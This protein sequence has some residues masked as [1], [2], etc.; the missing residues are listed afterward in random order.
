MT[1]L[2]KILGIYA[3][4]PKNGRKI[5]IHTFSEDVQDNRLSIL[6][7][8]SHTLSSQHSSLPA[9]RNKLRTIHENTQ[10]NNIQINNGGTH[11]KSQT[12]KALCAL[13]IKLKTALVTAR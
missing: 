10:V 13:I 7:K 9:L 8:S 1:Q 4:T 12:Y 2:T 6:S 5:I 11:G 3:Y